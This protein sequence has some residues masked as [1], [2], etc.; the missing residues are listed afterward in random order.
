MTETESID[1]FREFLKTHLSRLESYEWRSGSLFPPEYGISPREYLAYAEDRLTHPDTPGSMIDCLGHLKRAM[2]CQLDRFL[3]TIN[4][5]AVFNKKSLGIDK[6]LEFLAR[7]GVF[8]SRTLSRLNRL[9]NKM[10][11]E[12]AAPDLTDLEV[13]ADLV[14]AFVLVLEKTILL[15]HDYSEFRFLMKDDEGIVQEKL[16]GFEI[17]LDADSEGVPPQVRIDW[18]LKEEK[19]CLDIA[20]NDMPSLASAIGILLLLQHREVFGDEKWV[21]DQLLA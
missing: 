12:Y 3:A 13:Y 16:G 20:T 7:A 14:T 11:H 8:Q 1:G 9:R 15:L 21:L 5:L 17:A 4:L 10:E 6:R 18:W 2:S 19:H